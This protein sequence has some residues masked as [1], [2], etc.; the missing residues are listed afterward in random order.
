[1]CPLPP[2]PTPAC[3]ISPPALT[4]IEFLSYF[5]LV[6]YL[7]VIQELWRHL[8]RLYT[9]SSSTPYQQDPNSFEINKAVMLK[10]ICN[11]VLL[12]IEMIPP[13][14]LCSTPLCVVEYY[15]SQINYF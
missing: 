12:N 5:S 6:K 7:E 2:P 9:N 14:K 3:P 15:R 4:V 10:Q 11:A 13:A 8:T 1:M